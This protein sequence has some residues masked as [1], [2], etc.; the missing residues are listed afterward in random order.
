MKKIAVVTGTRAGIRFT[1]LDNEGDSKLVLAY[2]IFGEWNT[3]VN[4]L[5]LNFPRR[6]F[7]G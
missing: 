1:L 6:K 3:D 4:K 5:L 2:R 7:F